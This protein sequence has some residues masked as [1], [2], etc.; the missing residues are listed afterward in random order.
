MKDNPYRQD[1][2]E[3]RE[4]VRQFENLKAGRSHTFLDEESFEKI[5]DHFDDVEDLQQAF[6]AADIAVDRYPYSAMLH[7]KKGDILIATRRYHEALKVL[8]HAQVLDQN[9]IN[10]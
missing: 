10:L 9:D 5:I 8:N 6:E 4:L 7:V 2:E 3:I 1:K